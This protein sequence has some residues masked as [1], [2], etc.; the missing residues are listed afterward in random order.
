MAGR[1]VRRKERKE[2]RRK[3]TVSRICEN[4]AQGKSPVPQPSF[5][6]HFPPP[7]PSLRPAPARAPAPSLGRNFSRPLSP[8]QAAG[9]LADPGLRR[10]ISDSG[11]R[12]TTS[13]MAGQRWSRCAR[14]AARDSSAGFFFFCFVLPSYNHPP[15]PKCSFGFVG[16]NPARQCTPGK[17][18]ARPPM[19]A[20][21]PGSPRL[22]R[23]L[24]PTWGRGRR[25]PAARYHCPGCCRARPRLAGR[26][27]LQVLMRT[28]QAFH[29]HGS[30]LAPIYF[31]FKNYTHIESKSSLK[32]RYPTRRERI[33]TNSGQGSGRA[34]WQHNSR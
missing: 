33:V 24:L 31:G 4:R 12:R 27:P 7:T 21:H 5:V 22:R 29:P 14:P 18:G 16:K 11:Q 20:A 8:G 19:G 25:L 3:D 23:G 17:A 13:H 9:A 15:L 10:H 1:R 28:G 32:R 6:H 30:R 34:S 26:N 2:E